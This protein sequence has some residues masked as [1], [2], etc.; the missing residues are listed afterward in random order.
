METRLA[1][2]IVVDGLRAAALGTYGNT[3]S[4]T[5]QLDLLAS[6]SL[7]CEW[8]IAD[9]PGLAGFYRG[10]W[11]GSHVLQANSEAIADAL[12]RKLQQAGVRSWLLT[13]D[14]GLAER[15]GTEGFAEVKQILTPPAQSAA[16]L[17]QTHF[18]EFFSQAIDHIIP[19]QKDVAEHAGMGMLWIHLQG[20][21]G[22]WDAPLAMRAAFVDEED[23][24]PPSFAEPPISGQRVEDPDL[25]WSFRTAYAA[26]LEILDTCLGAFLAEWEQL[27][28]CSN[29]LTTLIGSQGFSLGEH[30]VVGCDPELL[31]GEQLQLP[32]FIA[33]SGSLQPPGRGQGFAIPADLGATLTDWFGVSAKA[34]PSLGRSVLP[35]FSESPIP[36]RQLAITRSPSGELSVRTSAW[37]LKLPP[38]GAPCQLFA[39]PDD[40]WEVNDIA[41]RCPEIIEELTALTQAALESGTAG[42]FSLEQDLGE[43]LNAP[44]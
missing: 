7:V 42:N 33:T 9:E 29:R 11:N 40:R 4:P 24:A 16:E 37:L 23:L 12:P 27:A 3:I 19:W 13:D 1:L 25:L 15:G 17:E 2:V 5:P 22:P 32:W 34:P 36:E 26:Q 14:P 6:R 38:A 35:L 8:L 18:A 28:G 44:H 20:L 31:Y 21:C 41:S 30:L 39:K 10:V 43:R